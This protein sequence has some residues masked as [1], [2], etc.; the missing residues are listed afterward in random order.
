MA[1]PVDSVPSGIADALGIPNTTKVPGNFR[2]R[3][4]T[5]FVGVLTDVPVFSFPT[6]TG[7]WLL[8]SAR[9][10]AN[11]MPVI[12]QTSVGI[13]IATTNPFPPSTGPIRVQIPFTRVR[14][15]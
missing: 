8:G 10:R 6:A 15:L 7:Q 5:G 9:C 1:N 4:T 13:G 2:A 3:T 11:G 14:A 12:T